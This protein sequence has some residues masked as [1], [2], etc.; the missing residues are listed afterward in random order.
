MELEAASPNVE[1]RPRAEALDPSPASPL[2]DDIGWCMETGGEGWNPP[3]PVMEPLWAGC[4]W[5][6]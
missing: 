2:M 3:G 4:I 6:L 1:P 5:P